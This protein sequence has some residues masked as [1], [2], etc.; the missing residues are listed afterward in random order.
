M[1]V[2]GIEYLSFIGDTQAVGVIGA[3]STGAEFTQSLQ[4]PYSKLEILNSTYPSKPT[5]SAVFSSK[6]DFEVALSS[7]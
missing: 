3:I 2:V 4:S 1:L 5:P 6:A 7:S